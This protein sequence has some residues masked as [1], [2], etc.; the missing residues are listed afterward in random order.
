MALNAEADAKG[1]YRLCAHSPPC[2]WCPYSWA[3][4]GLFRL[5]RRVL[6][7]EGATC[8]QC[9]GEREEGKLESSLGYF[10]VALGLGSFWQV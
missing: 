7:K 10:V 1:Q 5:W 9:A 2:P 8:A 3:L 4:P 6:G